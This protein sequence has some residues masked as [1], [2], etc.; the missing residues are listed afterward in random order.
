MRQMEPNFASPSG[1]FA[2]S[3]MPDAGT[4]LWAGLDDDQLE[5]CL[6]D[7]I[8]FSEFADDAHRANCARTRDELVVEC[9]LR[10]R[11]ELIRRAWLRLASNSRGQR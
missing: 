3:A 6:G 9:A 5:A 1:P 10:D 2:I 8:W 11:H 7:F 4:R